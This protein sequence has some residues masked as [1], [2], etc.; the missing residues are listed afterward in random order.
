MGM[1]EEGVTSQGATSKSFDKYGKRVWVATPK[2]DLSKKDKK[3]S[4]D[5]PAEC[6]DSNTTRTDV[7]TE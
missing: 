6:V 1:L 7:G 5:K 4:A 3:L 2:K